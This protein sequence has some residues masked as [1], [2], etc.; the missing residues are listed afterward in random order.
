MNV[1]LKANML[2][3]TLIAKGFTSSKHLDRNKFKSTSWLSL[4]Y[5]RKHEGW[6]FK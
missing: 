2:Y 3:Q 4:K 1:I 6:Y 5:L